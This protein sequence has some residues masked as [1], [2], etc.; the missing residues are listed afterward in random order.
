[1]TVIQA[2][3]G[4]SRL[5]HHAKKRPDPH[6]EDGA[7]SA[8]GN[9][10]RHA[11]DIAHAD[12]AAQCQAECSVRGNLAVTA[13]AGFRAAGKNRVFHRMAEMHKGKEFALDH[14]VDAHDHD[15][16]DQR[17]APHPAVQLVQKVDKCHLRSLTSL[18]FG[19]FRI[20]CL[21]EYAGLLLRIPVIPF[22]VSI[23]LSYS[24]KSIGVFC[25]IPQNAM[26]RLCDICLL[27]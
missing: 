23:V 18:F 2:Q 7:R 14:V 15:Q 20:R 3:G 22:D 9:G 4:L 11:G 8:Y 24:V 6:P 25:K 12:G 10:G 27:S 21:L 26:D 17:C 13:L 1:M 19:L 16:H 5:D